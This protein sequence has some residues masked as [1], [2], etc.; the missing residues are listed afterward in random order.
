MVPNNYK[1]V[2]EDTF[3]GFE[4]DT[5]KWRDQQPWGRLHAG[6]PYQYYGKDS[7]HVNNGEISVLRLNI[8][9]TVFSSLNPITSLK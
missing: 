4:L 9:L 2:F 7:I 6:S 5:D 1:L 8:V 3:Q